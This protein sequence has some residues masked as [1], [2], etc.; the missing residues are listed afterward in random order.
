MGIYSQLPLGATYD[1]LWEFFLQLGAVERKCED[2]DALNFNARVK[3]KAQKSKVST[4]CDCEDLCVAAEGWAVSFKPNTR[5][6][7]KSKCYCHTKSRR[8][9]KEKR[10][11]GLSWIKLKEHRKQ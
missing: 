10:S 9:V 5:N 7:M 3:G 2:D 6:E 4:L 1:L 11:K 8:K